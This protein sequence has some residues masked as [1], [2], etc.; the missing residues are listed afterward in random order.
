VPSP[1]IEKR[2]RKD[3]SMDKEKSKDKKQSSFHHSPKR[4]RLSAFETSG[5]HVEPFFAPNLTFFQGVSISLSPIEKGAL[6]GSSTVDLVATCFEMHS[7]ILA[8][9]K[10]LRSQITKGGVAELAKIKELATSSNS[11]KEV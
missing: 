1:K 9:T 5:G 3:K 11:L 8:I 7:Q 10:V 6:S 4:P 2:K